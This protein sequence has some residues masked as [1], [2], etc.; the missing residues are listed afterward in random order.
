MAHEAEPPLKIL[1]F[2]SPDFPADTRLRVFHTEYH[3]NSVLLKMQSKFFRAFLDSAE[4]AASLPACSEFKYEWVTKIDYDDT[5]E[6][7]LVSATS[8]RLSINDASFTGNKQQEV[9]DFEIILRAIYGCP[10]F[11][12]DRNQLCRV[13]KLADYYDALRILS[14]SLDCPGQR[15]DLKHMNLWEDPCGMLRIAKKLRNA[16]LFQECLT[17]S[18]G[19]LSGPKFFELQFSV[20]ELFKLALSVTGQIRVAMVEAHNCLMQHLEKLREENPSLNQE[21]QNYLD[22]ILT[23]NPLPHV[24][25]KLW[26]FQS[27]ICLDDWPFRKA[28]SPMSNLLRSSLVINDHAEAGKGEFEDHFLCADFD[29]VKLPWNVVDND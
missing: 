8:P 9:W 12:R 6:W 19:P 29:K 13:T 23:K 1:P 11:I 5:N 20:P 3:V 27:I 18:A 4:K 2:K 22:C 10:L 7:S 17:L 21:M 25:N 28:G 26:H 16:T 24:Y 14:R 15:Y